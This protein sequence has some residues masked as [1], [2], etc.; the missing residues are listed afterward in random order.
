[1][2]RD[3]T[4][5]F[6]LSHNGALEMAKWQKPKQDKSIKEKSAYGKIKQAERFTTWTNVCY[7]DEDAVALEKEWEVRK[8]RM[9]AKHC[10]ER[11]G[12]K[13]PGQSYNWAVAFQ[14]K[15]GMTLI[16]YINDFVR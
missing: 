2:V 15:T 11:K 9:F 6:V 5:A 1:M 4:T 7:P 16:N 8:I 12:K 10:W 13:V 3:T 14:D